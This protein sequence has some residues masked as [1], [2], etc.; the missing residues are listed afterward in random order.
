V[1]SL[2]SVTHDDVAPFLSEFDDATR[3]AQNEALSEILNHATVKQRAVLIEGKEGG[4]DKFLSMIKE[5]AVID[6]IFEKEFAHHK[7][8]FQSA[9]AAKADNPGNDLPPLEEPSRSI[10][11]E[12][13]VDE[14]TRA[15]R[16]VVD[17]VLGEF[18]AALEGKTDFDGRTINPDTFEISQ[19]HKT[20]ES[21]IDSYTIAMA[22]QVITN[23]FQ[24]AATNPEMSHTAKLAAD[25][26]SHPRGRS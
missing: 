4:L 9:A 7:F 11:I 1:A 3:E 15:V 23:I 18:I 17:T 20:G 16:D 8:S 12:E 13:Y 2:D 19:R 14:K 21:D 25:G 5:Q 24:E 6:P 26:E 22:Q 10:F